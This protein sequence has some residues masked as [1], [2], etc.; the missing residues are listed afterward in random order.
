MWAAHRA[1]EWVRNK[2]ACNRAPVACIRV[3]ATHAGGEE[4]QET[5]RRKL[6]RRRKKRRDL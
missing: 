6:R 4:E 2:N 3:H 1:P 5:Q